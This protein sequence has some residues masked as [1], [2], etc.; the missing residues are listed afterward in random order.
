MKAE[1]NYTKFAIV[2]LL[3]A[4]LGISV[5]T[6]SLASDGI[7]NEDKTSLI[8]TKIL[9]KKV[10]FALPLENGKV[11]AKFGRRVH[12]I[13]GQEIFHSGVDIATDKGTEIY[14]VASGKVIYADFDTSNGNM[15][16]IEHAD[17][18]VSVY[19]HGSEIL[20]DVG[21]EVEVGEKI[22]LVGM[23]GMAT[24][25]HL[26]VEVIDKNGEYV[27]INYLFE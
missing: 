5:I 12:P 22:M 10:E 11:S 24:G 27:D 8:D 16:K 9:E 15:V 7:K 18:S 2:F 3:V 23:T 4:I 19:K 26:H 17:G 1:K 21:E 13:T 20:V 14:A 6:V 25:P